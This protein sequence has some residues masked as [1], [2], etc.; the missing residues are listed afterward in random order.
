MVVTK[1]I[2]VQEGKIYPFPTNIFLGYFNIKRYG[3]YFLLLY[4]FI[5]LV[6][7]DSL[8]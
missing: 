2:F 1:L 6:E 7:G 5:L 3:V 8:S 4:Q